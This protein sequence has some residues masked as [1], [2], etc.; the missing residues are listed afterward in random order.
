[1]QQPPLLVCDTDLLVL[2]IWSEVRFGQCHDW[3]IETYAE[4]T[5][6]QDRHYLLCSYD[7]PWEP[8]PLRENPDD[9]KELFDLYREK[10]EF[11]GLNYDIIAGT[12][13]ERLSKTKALLSTHSP[14]H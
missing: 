6:T 8:D 13:D 14:I 2:V 3:I 1:M 9:R 10:L 7:V 4:Q 11:L 12:V 5:R